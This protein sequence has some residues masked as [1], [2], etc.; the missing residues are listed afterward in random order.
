[1][2][3]GWRESMP[4]SAVAPHTQQ[5]R[6]HLKQPASLHTCAA[7]AAAGLGR[8]Q[9]AVARAHKLAAQRPQHGAQWPRHVRE[10][11]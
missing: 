2:A 8:K 5:R 11:A 6:W 10:L 4:P 7:A 3:D 9:R 1:M